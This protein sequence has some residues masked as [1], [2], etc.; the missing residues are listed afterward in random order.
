MRNI[1][2]I[3]LPPRMA[4]VV[5]KT[6]R[7]SGFSSKSEFFRMLLRLWMEGK[8]VEELEESRKELK[9]GRGKFLR[10]LRDLR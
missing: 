3:S 7:R 5:E 1:I 2:N 6:V 8:L 9:E 4:K 10:T